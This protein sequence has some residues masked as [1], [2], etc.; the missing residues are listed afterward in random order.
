MTDPAEEAGPQAPATAGHTDTLSSSRAVSERV[1]GASTRI[2]RLALPMTAGEIVGYLQMLALVAMVGRMGGDALYVRSLFVPLGMLFGALNSALAVT[3]QVAC[4]ISKGR[5]APE[6]AFPIAVSMMKVWVALGTGLTVLVTAC[7]PLLAAFFDVSASARPDFIR[8]LCWMSLVSLL[9]FGPAVCASALRAFGFVRQALVV[10]LSGAALELGLVG[11]LGLGAGMGMDSLPVAAAVTA[12]AGTLA[13]LWMLR[14]TGLSSAGQRSPWQPEVIGLIK[15]VGVPVALTIGVISLYSL[16]MIRV[17]SPFGS[18]TVSGFAT[19]SSVQSLVIMPGLVLGS[20]AAIVL[21]QQ[22]G[23]GTYTS[24]GPTYAGAVRIAFGVYAVI[25]LVAWAG[26]DLIAQV[27]TDDPVVA[28]QAARYLAIV[29]LTYVLQGPVLMALTLMEHVG[30]GQRALLLNIG[31]FG[32]NIIAGYWASRAF[33]SPDGLYWAVA[34]S[35]LQG[36]VVL[37]IAAS[38]MRTLA[39]KD[40]GA[41]TP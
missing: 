14:R 6:K 19:A 25:A 18:A 30:G 15:S 23:A 31:Y 22:R 29:A 37:L 16:A 17:L 4:S 11:A 12:V 21:N 39:S 2:R 38:F 13:G 35:N 20:A 5:N 32:V 10:S 34:A 8:F 40:D 9:G 36:V 3:A 1:P 7:S 28:E 26:R 24:L 33:D 41:G 27:M